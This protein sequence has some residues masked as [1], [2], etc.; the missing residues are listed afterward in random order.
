M[1]AR[2][3]PTPDERRAAVLETTGHRG[4]LLLVLIVVAIVA[5]LALA[6]PT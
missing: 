6:L 2:W 3:E 4:T 1:G 5:T